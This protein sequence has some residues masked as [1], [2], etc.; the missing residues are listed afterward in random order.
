[1]HRAK[2]SNAFRWII[3]K[4]VIRTSTYVGTNK[5]DLVLY[6]AKDEDAKRHMFGVLKYRKI[7]YEVFGRWIWNLSKC[8]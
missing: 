7:T 4:Q 8:E 5:Q 3:G 2:M 1:M 6:N